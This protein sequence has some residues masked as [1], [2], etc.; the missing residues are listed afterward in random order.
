MGLWK[1]RLAKYGLD[2]ANDLWLKIC[3]RD[4]SEWV[5]PERKSKLAG[6]S[7]NAYYIAAA[8]SGTTSTPEVI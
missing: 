3:N 5:G 7:S 8:C 6:R 4:Y 1:Q 2:G